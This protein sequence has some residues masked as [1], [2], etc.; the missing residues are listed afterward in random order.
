MDIARTARAALE[1]EMRRAEVEDLHMAEG[2][3][4]IG[5][6]AERIAEFMR[7]DFKLPAA[8]DFELSDLT[9]SLSVSITAFEAE[10]SGKLDELLSR[11]TQL[12]VLHHS[13]SGLISAKQLK[14]QSDK[15]DHSIRGVV[16]PNANSMILLDA[17]IWHLL[18]RRMLTTRQWR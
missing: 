2:S 3:H 17:C 18:Y 10:V 16:Q 13:K 15:W 11:V 14:V 9:E 6:L 4:E 12:R 1:H 5:T 8:T 7:L